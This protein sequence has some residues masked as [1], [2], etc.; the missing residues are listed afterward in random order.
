MPEAGIT[1]PQDRF[2]LSGKGLATKAAQDMASIYNSLVICAFAASKLQPSQI[3]ELLTLTTGEEYNGRRVLK[4]G[5]RITNLQRL[6]NLRVGM[7]PQED[8][9]PRRLLEPTRTGPTAGRVPNVEEQL[10]EY[11]EVR[12]WSPGGLPLPEKLEEL[13]LIDLASRIPILSER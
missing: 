6:L 1:E 10:R 7:D 3:G 8:K 4:T 2:G 13:G 12:G 9:L 11:Y 5:E